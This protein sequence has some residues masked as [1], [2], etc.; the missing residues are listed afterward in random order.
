MSTSAS[1]EIDFPDV[2]FKKDDQEFYQYMTKKESA[3]PFSG[4]QMSDVFIYAMSLG[5]KKEKRTPYDDK[6]NRIP[7]MPPTAFNSE[8][9]WL[10]R[11]VSITENEELE[12]IMNHH[13]VVEIAEEYANT[14]IEI[15]KQ[16]MDKQT[17]DLEQDAVFESDLRKQIEKI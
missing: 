6:K 2:G 1:F 3:T 8:M 17:I 4:F 16:F 10:M 12:S 14:G 5:F 9:R 11:S 15:M 7:N 13:K